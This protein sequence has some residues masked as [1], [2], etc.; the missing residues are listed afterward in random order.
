MQ[1]VFLFALLAVN[2]WFFV[3]ALS[4]TLYFRRSTSTPRVKGGPFVSVIVPARNEEDSIARCVGS[5][6]KQDYADYEVI[7]VDDGSTDATAKIVTAL[8]AGESRLRLVP[9]GTLPDGWLGKPHALSQGA[10]VARGEVLLFTDADTVHEPESLSWAVTNLRNSRADILSGY[11][12]QDYTTLGDRVI[13]PVLYAMMLMVPLYLLPRTRNPRLSFAIGQ[14]V[15]VRREAFDGIGGLEAIKDSMVEDMSMASRMKELGYRNVFLDAKKAASC[16]MYRGYRDAFEGIERPIYSAVGGR[17]VTVIALTVLA[18][19]VIV[20]PASSLIVPGLRFGVPAGPIAFSVVLFAVQ[21]AVLVWDRNM[22]LV[23]FVLYPL[24]F[25]NLIL[26]LNASM[27]STGFGPGVLWKGRRVRVPDGFAAAP[28]ECP[29][30]S[31][32]KAK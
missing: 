30:D 6:L 7:V 27:L 12:T 29:A 9:A 4:N 24:V 17:P 2:G 5:L 13:V 23:A 25:L 18:S 16:R 8:Q 11:L 32:G 15:V 21:W 22:P 20:W 14:Y 28:E 31:A 10:A 1:S 3:T 26:I 19:G